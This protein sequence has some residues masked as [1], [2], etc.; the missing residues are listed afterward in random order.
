MVSKF[1]LKINCSGACTVK[2]TDSLP[3]EKEKNL[4]RN[5]KIDYSAIVSPIIREKYNLTLI[6]TSYSQGE[7]PSSLELESNPG[8]LDSM[9]MF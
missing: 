8:H 4:R 5:L 1:T 6:P 3:M 9:R 2:F 7:K